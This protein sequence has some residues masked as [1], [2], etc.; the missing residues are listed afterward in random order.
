ML[1]KTNKTHKIQIFRNMV[2]TEAHRNTHP[3]PHYTHKGMYTQVDMVS[4][5]CKLHHL[6]PFLGKQ[7]SSCAP[8]QTCT[9]QPYQGIWW[10][11]D[12]PTTSFLFFHTPLAFSQ[13]SYLAVHITLPDSR[14][15]RKGRG[16]VREEDGAIDRFGGEGW[17][18]YG[19]SMIGQTVCM[20]EC[21]AIAQGKHKLT[22]EVHN[23]S[24]V[25]QLRKPLHFS[26]AS[27]HF[28]SFHLPI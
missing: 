16:G 8:K 19:T 12:D 20:C 17:E 10:L 25:P 21:P 9:R 1:L 27:R 24:T 2:T 13:P 7:L 5:M 23:F 22:W 6:R 14:G 26:N 4:G 3:W 11:G 15:G 28:F 18:K